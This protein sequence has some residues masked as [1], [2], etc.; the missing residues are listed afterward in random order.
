[1]IYCPGGG[2]FYPIWSTE[3]A[4]GDSECD[5][6]FDIP[7]ETARSVAGY[8]HDE[9]VPGLSGEV[10]E[11]LARPGKPSFWKRL[12]GQASTAQLASLARDQLRGI[13][14]REARIQLLEEL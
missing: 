8:R 6:L 4:A 10:F 9:D 12:L 14:S 11:V 5:Y 2:C 3:Q 1:M 13:L 7:V